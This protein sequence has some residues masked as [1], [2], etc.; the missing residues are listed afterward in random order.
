MQYIGRIARSSLRQQ[1]FL[2]ISLNTTAIG[3]WRPWTL[4]LCSRLLSSSN[5]YLKEISHRLR[6]KEDKKA[7]KI[8]DPSMAGRREKTAVWALLQTDGG[9]QGRRPTVLL[10]LS[11]DGACHVWWAG[12]ESGAKDRET[13]Y[14]H[15]EGKSILP[16]SNETGMFGLLIECRKTI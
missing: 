2:V 8:P 7:Q 16:P 4:L 14:Q 3:P 9:A 15:E 6:K 10:Q 5:S 13:W 12:A 11:Q 1:G